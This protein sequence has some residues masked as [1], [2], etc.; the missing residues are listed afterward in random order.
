[1]KLKNLTTAFEKNEKQ[2]SATPTPNNKININLHYY[3]IMIY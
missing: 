2:N 3:I 1:M